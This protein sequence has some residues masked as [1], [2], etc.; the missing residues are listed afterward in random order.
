M[1]SSERQRLLTTDE[2]GE[3]WM[4]FED[5]IK[6]YTDL[7]ICSISVDALYEDDGGMYNL[8]HIPCSP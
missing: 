1:S 6:H 3:F 5:M 7:E 4:S 2:D 8:S